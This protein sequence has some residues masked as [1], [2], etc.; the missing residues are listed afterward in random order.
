MANDFWTARRSQR[1]RHR[2][3]TGEQTWKKHF[4]QKFNKN[5][6]NNENEDTNRISA[7][8]TDEEVI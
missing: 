2:L 4:N 7:D 3:K 8:V 1:I 6:E 5:L